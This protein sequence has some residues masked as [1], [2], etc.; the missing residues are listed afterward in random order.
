MNSTIVATDNELKTELEKATTPLLLYFWATWCGPCKLVSPSVE[1]AA[2][3][4]GDRLKVIKMQVDNREEFEAAVD[5]YKVEG[6]PALRVVKNE[7]ILVSHEGGITK[8]KLVE[9]LE[10]HL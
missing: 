1:W 10:Q 5:R 2:K 3:E 6:L 4:Y 8:N 7:E 9:M